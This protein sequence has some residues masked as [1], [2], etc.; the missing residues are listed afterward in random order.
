[1]AGLQEVHT[2]STCTSSILIVSIVWCSTRFDRR[3]RAE[4]EDPAPG[5][6][7]CQGPCE[8]VRKLL[9]GDLGTSL[10]ELLLGGLGVLLLGPLDDDLG[11]SLDGLLGLPL[12]TVG[13][14]PDD[15]DD[16]ERL[17]S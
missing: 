15:L 14:G 7:V 16:G 13:Q 12:T 6:L 11:S 3:Q 2:A 1:M 4:S 10:L 8:C 9:E 5:T 17:V